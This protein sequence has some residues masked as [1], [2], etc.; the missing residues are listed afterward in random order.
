MPALQGPARLEEGL[1]RARLQGRPPRVPREGRHP[2]DAR[3]GSAPASPGR[4][5]LSAP[6]K[7]VIPA[8]MRST[9]LAGKMLADIAGK[10]LVAWVAE[11]AKAS[12]AA[13]VYI[14]TDHDDIA[15]AV[16]A[17]GWKALKTS[18]AHETGTHRLAE[19]ASLLALGDDEIVVNVQGDEPLIDPRLIR[20]VGEALASHRDAS[21]ATAAHPI[22]SAATIFDPNVEKVVVC[23]QRLG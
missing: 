14:A 18:A 7:V 11:R 15:N 16:A 17:L 2:R 8:R 12:G 4:R 19:A 6:F 23:A 20:E 13:A 22:Q 9:R 3:G 21:I 5:A 10:P 1:A